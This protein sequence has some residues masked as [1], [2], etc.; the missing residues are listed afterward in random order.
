VVA[1]VFRVI[2]S[3]MVFGVTMFC[4]WAMVFIYRCVYR[5]EHRNSTY[6]R[7]TDAEHFSM[8]KRIRKS[9][10]LYT[11]L[12][13]LCWILPTL[14]VLS[15]PALRV[16]ADT[17]VPLMGFFNVLVFI[18]PR[19]LKYQKDHAGTRLPVAYFHVMFGT[20][21]AAVRQGVASRSGAGRCAGGP[22]TAKSG[23]GLG[24]YNKKTETTAPTDGR[25]SGAERKPPTPL[26]QE[27]ND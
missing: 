12:F 16:V 18:L 9:M 2:L 8:S 1:N 25:G 24:S 20:P 6:G 5:Q 15:L 19:C 11:S 14:L 13:Y 4:T 10:L 3:L 21:L 22:G 26:C 23:I 7:G 17:L 27:L